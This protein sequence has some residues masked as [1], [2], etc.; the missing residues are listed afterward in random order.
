MFYNE[1]GWG[2]IMTTGE[3]IALLRRK[4]GVTQEELAESL[5]V[6]RQ[7]VSRWEMDVTF[8]ETDKL[9]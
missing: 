6:S 2:D 8:P 1:Y 9:I 4:K 7:S 3:K 5:K